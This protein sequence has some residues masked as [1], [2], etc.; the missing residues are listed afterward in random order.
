MFPFMFIRHLAAIG[1]LICLVCVQKVS[2]TSP[3]AHHIAH[4]R[5]LGADMPPSPSVSHLSGFA[6]A[7]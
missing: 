4:R 2:T 3:R 1:I 5:N 7:L 6:S